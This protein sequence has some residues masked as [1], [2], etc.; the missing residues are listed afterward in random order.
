MFKI[1]WNPVL[2]PASQTHI[3]HELIL[4]YS[5]IDVHAGDELQVVANSVMNRYLM[6][7]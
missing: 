1:H 2:P 4:I 6:T 5:E 3:L 7:Y